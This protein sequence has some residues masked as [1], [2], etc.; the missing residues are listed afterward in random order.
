MPVR[1]WLVD[2][3]HRWVIARQS[4]NGDW[5]FFAGVGIWSQDLL[6]GAVLFNALWSAEEARTHSADG[7]GTVRNAAEA[8]DFAV[9]CLPVAEVPG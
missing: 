4:D 3:R 2:L 6:N 9:V 5:E 1:C 7:Q 8:Y